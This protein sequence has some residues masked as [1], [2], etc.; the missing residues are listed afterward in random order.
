MRIVIVTQ[1]YPPEPV[2]I[3]AELARGLHHLGH[4]VCV[5]TGTPNYPSGK[6]YPGYKLRFR[7][8][9]VDGG[10]RVRRV[11]LLASHS[12]NPLARILSFLVSQSLP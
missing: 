7:S 1:F 12:R 5:V 11:P 8:D 9:E 10:V 3:P 6:V 4:E 2:P